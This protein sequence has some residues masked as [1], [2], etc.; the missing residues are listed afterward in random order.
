MAILYDAVLNPTKLDLLAHWLPSQSWFDA[1]SANAEAV[2][3]FRF[4]DPDGEVGM[5]THLVAAGGKVFHAPLTYRGA[6]LEG[7][8]D[9]LLGTMDHSM[10]GRR[11]I[12]DACGD[13]VYAAA[14]AAT[15]IT[16]RPQAAQFIDREGRLEEVPSLVHIEIIGSPKTEVPGVVHA[17]PVA[18]GH[19]TTVR[20]G[21]VDLIV[22]R[23]LDLNGTTNGASV[24]TGIWEGQRTPVQLAGI[25]EA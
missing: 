16:G 24:M 12:Y 23:A 5:E 21:A 4:D 22:N 17:E 25:S 9:W 2:G 19:I 20:T 18:A 3:S 1:G 15:L 14:L 6:P 8:G 13:P 11:W 7:A 10:L